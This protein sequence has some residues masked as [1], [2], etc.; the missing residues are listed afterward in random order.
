MIFSASCVAA[1]DCAGSFGAGAAGCAVATTPESPNAAVLKTET[2]KLVRNSSRERNAR[3]CRFLIIS[4]L[5]GCP[6]VPRSHAIT[7]VSPLSRVPLGTMARRNRRST[8]RGARLPC[9]L[10]LA[11]TVPKKIIP[12]GEGITPTRCFFAHNSASRAPVSPKRFRLTPI[13]SIRERWRLHARRFSLPLS[14]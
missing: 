11:K 14:M 10:A 2:C 8:Q 9:G 1:A 7:Q 13:R 4:T 5:F 12:P 3:I 6:R